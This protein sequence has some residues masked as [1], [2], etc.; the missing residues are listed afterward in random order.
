[1]PYTYAWSNAA[2]TASITGV[3]DGT[4]TVTI[5]DNNACTSTNTSTIIVVD[6]VKPTVLIQN[7]NAHLDAAGNV[8]ITT[9]DIDN[10]ST[11]ICGAPT[12]SLDVSSFTCADVGANTVY[13]RVTD[14]NGNVDSAMATVTVIDTIKPTVI[15][16]NINSYIDATGNVTITTADVDHG[17]TDICGAPTLSLDVSSFTCAEVGANTVTLTATDVNSNVASATATITVL[18]TIKPLISNCVPNIFS[19]TDVTGCTTV[20]NWT[21]PTAADNCNVD[22]LVSSHNP[23]DVFALGTTTVTY[24][25]YDPS[26]NTDTCS[27]NIVVS[28]AFSPIITNMPADISI[29]NDAGKCDA[30][31]TWTLP[32]ASDNCNVDSLVSTAQSGDVFAVGTTTVIYTAYD[33]A[34]NTSVDSFMVTVNDTELPTIVCPSD[35]AQCDSI[36]YWTSPIGNDNCSVATT[37]RSDTMMYSSGDEFPIGTTTI[38]YQVTDIHNNQQTCDFDVTVFTPPVAHAGE[39]L[40][41][42]DIEPVR[43]NSSATN[44]QSVLWTWT[45][46]GDLDALD[47]ETAVAPLANPKETTEYIMTVTS[48]DG[49]VDTDTM[50]INVEVVEILEATNMFSPNGDGRNDTWV[51]N[52]T[53]L[54]QGCQL[55]IVNRNGT[56]VFSTS[57]YNNDWDATISGSELPEGTYYYIIDC[58]D[59]RQ[60]KGHIDVIREKR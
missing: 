37:L 3:A 56:E 54:I 59:E 55:I 25:A 5:T 40:N 32:S 49:C 51:I 28:D 23:G 48:P 26:L 30:V 42:R 9:A 12:L 35:I 39:D 45:P 16:Q 14:V 33:A 18:D 60:F 11:D 6:T 19:T 15:T 17:S 29:S 53:D 8:S 21:A 24:I 7:M 44:A 34:M 43:I 22:S 58:P 27:F 47:E 38:S 20:I 50:N 4:Y 1:M 10:G 36:V 41:T 13:L 46:F 52:K 57:N 2:T 31:V